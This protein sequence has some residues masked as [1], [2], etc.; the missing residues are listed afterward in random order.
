ML[1][2]GERPLVLERPGEVDA[3]L[4]VATPPT[5]ARPDAAALDEAGRAFEGLS[6][7][8]VRRA[9]ALPGAALGEARASF[10]DGLAI[11]LWARADG[12]DLWVVL[13]AEGGEEAAALNA[14][15][16]GYGFQLPAWRARQLIPRL[17]DLLDP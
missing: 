11:R 16:E 15:W 7:E 4:V 9:D 2:A 3:P 12:D 8:E 1:R 10:T 14:S 13:R 6:L 17:E 5:A